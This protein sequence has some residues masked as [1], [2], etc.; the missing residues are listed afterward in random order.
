MASNIRRRR[1]NLSVAPIECNDGSEQLESTTLF[2][3]YRRQSTRR[4]VDPYGS[5]GIASS[6]TQSTVPIYAQPMMSVPVSVP[7]E[8]PRVD[9][10]DTSPIYIKP[11]H[12]S[13]ETSDLT[14]PHTNNPYAQI[15]HTP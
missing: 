8:M 12:S 1:S 15:T 14:T 3:L 9:S 2:H 5:V 10:G 7:Y 4:S 6:I 13:L 11:N